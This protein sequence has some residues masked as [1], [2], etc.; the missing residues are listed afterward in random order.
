MNKRQEVPRKYFRQKEIC[1]VFL[2][3][4]N[5]SMLFREFSQTYRQKSS[6]NIQYAVVYIIF[7]KE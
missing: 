7:S 5:Y 4:R 1:C 3:L 6:N 2:Q